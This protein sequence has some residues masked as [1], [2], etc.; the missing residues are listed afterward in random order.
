MAVSCEDRCIFYTKQVILSF[1]DIM[2][3]PELSFGAPISPQANSNVKC[4][5]R[6]PQ[7]GS[8]KDGRRIVW[9]GST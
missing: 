2:P 7:I 9:K 3:D 6:P 8:S 5:M 1:P 4:E